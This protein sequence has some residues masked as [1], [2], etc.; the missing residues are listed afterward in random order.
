MADKTRELF[1]TKIEAGSREYFIFV[2]ESTTGAKY[3]TISEVY[4]VGN[5]QKHARI[6]IFQEHLSKFIEALEEALRFF[7]SPLLAKKSYSLK[8]IRQKYPKAYAKWTPEE[9]QTLRKGFAQG[10]SIETLANILQRQPSAIL[11]RLRKLPLI[12]TSPS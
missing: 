7:D 1:K 5:R 3:L 9:E 4:S 11:S 12:N 6:I 10:M 2:K 8:N